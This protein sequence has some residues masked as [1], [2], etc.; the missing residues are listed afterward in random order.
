[1]FK[2]PA[3]NEDLRPTARICI[4]CGYKVTEENRAQSLGLKDSSIEPPLNIPAKVEAT[5]VISES[6]IAS[7]RQQNSLYTQS[8]KKVFSL[9]AGIVIIA[10]IIASYFV[11]SKSQKVN[12]GT[13][14]PSLNLPVNSM[15]TKISE[16]M[17]QTLMYPHGVFLGEVISGMANG[18]GVYTAA[19]SGTIYEGQFVNDTFTGKGSM[20]WVNGDKFIGIWKNDIGISGVMTFAN[21]QVIQGRV[22]NA[23]FYPNGN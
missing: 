11:T 8:N 22:V 10:T 20:N 7:E 23:R 3:C 1:M 14:S 18:Q 16:N 17:S 12:N 5:Q 13:Q 6:A 2:C 4:K 19:R 21:G 15:P 9:I